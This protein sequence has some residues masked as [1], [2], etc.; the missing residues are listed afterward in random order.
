MQLAGWV[1][2]YHDVTTGRCVRLKNISL[3]TVESHATVAGDR[4]EKLDHAC[5]RQAWTGM[6]HVGRTLECPAGMWVIFCTLGKPYPAVEPRALIAH[7]SVV[8]RIKLSTPLIPNTACHGL[9][10]AVYR[11][12]HNTSHDYHNLP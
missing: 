10:T 3:T 8:K 4:C 12:V 2:A 6:L 7:R 1:P 9:P 5:T 11:G